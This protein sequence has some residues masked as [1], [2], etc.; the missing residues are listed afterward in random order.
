MES[1]PIPSDSEERIARNLFHSSTSATKAQ[2][3]GLASPPRTRS[4]ISRYVSGCKS[5]GRPR[6]R[7]PRIG[8]YGAFMFFLLCLAAVVVTAQ[9]NTGEW[10][11]LLCAE[12][13]ETL[14]CLFKM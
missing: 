5:T 11:V 2:E 9:F 12:G 8:F 7:K 4:K 1:T 13:K 10:R 14:Q 6:K 3:G